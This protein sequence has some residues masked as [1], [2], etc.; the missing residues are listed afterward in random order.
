MLSS[1]LINETAT[2]GSKSALPTTPSAVALDGDLVRS[3]VDLD[4]IVQGSQSNP[5]LQVTA[6][7]TIKIAEAPIEEPGAG[8]V[9]LHIRT[10]GICGQV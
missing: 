3:N 2:A 10:T 4:G 1:F 5:S 8:E 6:D 9:L 7:H